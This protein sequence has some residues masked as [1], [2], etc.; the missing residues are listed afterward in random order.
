MSAPHDR[1]TLAELV[2]SIREWL[3]RD[4]VAATDGRLK[5][6]ARVAVKVL[7]MVERELELGEQQCERQRERW[8]RLGVADDAELAA[9]IRDGSLDSRLA[10]VREAVLASVLDKLAVANP[11]YLADDLNGNE[12][13]RS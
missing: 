6:D 13:G 5:F 12:G 2:E 7:R 4:V 10:E 8:D 9:S 11:D 3:E 1:P